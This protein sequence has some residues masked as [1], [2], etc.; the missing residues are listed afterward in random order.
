MH[1]LGKI[2]KASASLAGDYFED[3]AILIVEHNMEGAIGFIMNRHFPRRLNELEEFKH[4]K[5]M[6]IFEGGP[7][8]QDML[9]FI[10]KCEA[11]GGELLPIDDEWLWGGD[12]RE[13]LNFIDLSLVSV[14]IAKFFVGYCGW[15]GGQLEAEIA[16]GT[17]EL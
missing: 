7:V 15:S 3:A 1:L 2:L 9:Y 11:L 6:P 16:E 8:Q 14:D 4:S 17:W 12:I 13:L 5:A 10:H